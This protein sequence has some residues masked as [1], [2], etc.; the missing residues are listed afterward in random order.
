MI[1]FL[2]QKKMDY[3]SKTILFKVTQK[4][5]VQLDF[6]HIIISLLLTCLSVNGIQFY[7]LN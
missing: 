2:W 7:D 1:I 4:E 6:K 5:R 3:G